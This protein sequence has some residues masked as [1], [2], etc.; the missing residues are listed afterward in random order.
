[1]Q[2]DAKKKKKKKTEFTA[3]AINEGDGLELLCS[4]ADNC[5][6]L[7]FFDPQYSKVK[8]V[9]RVHQ[10]PMIYQNQEN[11]NNFL[12]EISRILQPNGFCL[13][14]LAKKQLLHDGYFFTLPKKLKV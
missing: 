12:Q 9:I 10:A 13:M 3:N 5:A 4:L 7:V 2:L 14:W 6:K 1:M 8:D 11:I